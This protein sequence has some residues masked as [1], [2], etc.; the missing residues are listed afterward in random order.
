MPGP[1]Y[2]FPVCVLFGI[3]LKAGA[4]INHAHSVAPVFKNS[5]SLSGKPQHLNTPYNT[6]GNKLYMVGHQDNK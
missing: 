4:Q 2:L 1:K 3:F 5:E 6:A